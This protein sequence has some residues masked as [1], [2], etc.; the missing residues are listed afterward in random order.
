MVGG[1]C[2][3]GGAE[4]GGWAAFREL[5]SEL[6]VVGGDCAGS[7][8]CDSAALGALVVRF[9]AGVRAEVLGDGRSSGADLTEFL[10]MVNPM[11]KKIAHRIT[12]PKNSASILPV[13]SVISVSV[14]SSAGNVPK[15]LI[16]TASSSAKPLPTPQVVQ[17]PADQL[18]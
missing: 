8:F 14:A 16:E 15:G 17:G 11:P 13:P 9:E 7:P 6:L 18:K 5:L 10:P 12:S 3:C 4:D 1:A 2:S